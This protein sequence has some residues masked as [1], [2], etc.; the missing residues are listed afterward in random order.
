VSVNITAEGR[1]LVTPELEWFPRPD[2]TERAVVFIPGYN[3]DPDAPPA[4]NYGVHGM[5]IWWYL[6]GPRGAAHFGIF[7]EW[8][9]G[10]LRPGHGRSPLGYPVREA[11]QYPSGADLGYHARVP[12]WDGQEIYA[13]KE[14]GIIGGRCYCDG[15]GLQADSLAREFTQY[16]ESVIWAALEAEY[17]T[18][19]TE[20]S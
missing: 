2:G 20:E 15:S 10:E 16:G 9:P 7:T 4:R 5:E 19:K 13:R 12:Q 3:G 11:S 6:R 18:L 17:A 8:T 1:R 14:C